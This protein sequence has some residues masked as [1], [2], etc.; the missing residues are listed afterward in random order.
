[1]TTVRHAPGAGVRKPPREE[2][3]GVRAER[4]RGQP[5]YGD[6]RAARNLD[7]RRCSTAVGL[8]HERNLNVTAR[9]LLNGDLSFRAFMVISNS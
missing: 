8:E 3:A 5:A 6:L 7:G 4:C 9:I 2:T 1:M